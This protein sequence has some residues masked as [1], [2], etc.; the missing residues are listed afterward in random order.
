MPIK[1]WWEDEAQTIFCWHLEGHWTWEE[2]RARLPLAAAAQRSVDHRVD[3]LFDMR[4]TD[5]LP[6]AAVHHVR[7]VLASMPD[8][9]GLLVMVGPNIFVKAALATFSSLY[10]Q[11]AKKFRLVDT[12]D[13]AY[14]LLSAL[15]VSSA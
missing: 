1:L 8:N 9:V 7:Q 12:L 6:P 13:E 10:K 5:H 14:E 3:V 11:S 15:R 2:F 4:Q